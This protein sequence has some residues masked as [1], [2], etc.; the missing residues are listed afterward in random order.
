MAKKYYRSLSK[1]I[2]NIQGQIVNI[3]LVMKEIQQSLEIMQREQS[4]NDNISY[5]D[6]NDNEISL[7][8]TKYTEFETLNIQ[9]RNEVNFRQKIV[10][11]KYV[12]F[13]Y[14]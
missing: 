5:S 13:L 4:N 14:I 10:S 6:N 11:S 8:L 7:P 12:N 3:S 2:C 1:R 9:L